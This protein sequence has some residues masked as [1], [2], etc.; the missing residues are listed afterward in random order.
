[1]N[2]EIYV[3]IEEPVEEE[4]VERC[5]DCPN[6]Y[7]QE[8]QKGKGEKVYY[9]KKHMC[10]SIYIKDG[11]G[12]QTNPNKI[13]KWCPYIKTNKKK[14]ERKEEYEYKKSI[15]NTNWYD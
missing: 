5:A 3:D 14:R 4:A 1:M 11:C 15:K 10:G 8:I 9:I 2:K 6:G 13:S 7:W 12:K